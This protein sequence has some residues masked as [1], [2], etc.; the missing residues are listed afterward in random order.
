MGACC[1]SRGTVGNRENDL[2]PPAIKGNAYQKFELSF[3]FSRTFVEVFAKRVRA[4][5]EKDRIEK[6]GDGSTISIESLRAV[7]TTQAWAELKQDDSRVTKLIKSPVFRNTNGK[8]D[9][10]SLILFGFLHCPGDLEYKSEVLYGCLQEGGPIKQPYLSAKDKDIIPVITKL[11]YLC[12]V[13]LIQLMQE[14]DL[15]P[16]EELPEAD[17]IEYA[18]DEIYE[19]N[20]ID[21]LF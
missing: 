6:K 14:V 21:P 2:Q 13:E 4:A 10:N 16:I 17:E 3:P 5:A 9:A 7:F 19:W 11:V 15:D 8:I 18:V 12:T 20:Y 1:G